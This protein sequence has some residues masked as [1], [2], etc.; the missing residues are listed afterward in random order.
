MERKGLAS[1]LPSEIKRFLTFAP[2]RAD[3]P[4]V[5]WFYGILLKALTL[6]WLGY[7]VTRAIM[8]LGDKGPPE[9]FLV[10]MFQILAATILYFLGDG[11]CYGERNAVF[12][13]AAL[14]IVAIVIAA[15]ALK[16]GYRLETGTLVGVIIILFFPPVFSGFRN[17]RKLD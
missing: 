3:I 15:Y 7:G 14:S 2:A 4:V 6:L 11:L 17:L 10:V 5:I 9:A 12:S 16:F 8:I 1:V 13:L